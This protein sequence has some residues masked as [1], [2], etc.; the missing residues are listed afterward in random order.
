LKNSRYAVSICCFIRTADVIVKIP[1]ELRTYKR[2]SDKLAP[3]ELK[4]VHP[5]GKSPVITVEI[6]GRDK[7]LVLAESAAIVEYLCE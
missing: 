1:Y 2:K 7:S 5:L 4:Q 3:P 6:P